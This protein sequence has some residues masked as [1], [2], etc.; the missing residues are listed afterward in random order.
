MDLSSPFFAQKR[1]GLVH[2]EELGG[3]GGASDAQVQPEGLAESQEG[4]E[5]E[6]GGL[7]GLDLKASVDYVRC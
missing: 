4:E 6:A 5:K 3:V 2:H 1:R 7:R